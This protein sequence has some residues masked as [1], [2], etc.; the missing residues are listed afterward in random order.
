LPKLLPA[1]LPPLKKQP[2][3]KAVVDEHLDALNK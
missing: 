2:S 1:K 3:P